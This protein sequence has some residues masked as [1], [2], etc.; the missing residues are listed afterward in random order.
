M[1]LLIRYTKVFFDHIYFVTTVS[2][3]KIKQDNIGCSLFCTK[4]V[5]LV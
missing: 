5:N 1:Y 4:G 2:E 3:F